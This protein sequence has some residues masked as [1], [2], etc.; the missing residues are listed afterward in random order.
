MAKWSEAGEPMQAGR[1]TL[2]HETNALAEERW[3]LARIE[4]P[5]NLLLTRKDLV[6]LADLADDMCEEHGL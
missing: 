5:F 3:R 1:F 6:D 4:P 2:Q